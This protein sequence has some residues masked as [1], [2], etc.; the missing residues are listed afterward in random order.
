M[1]RNAIKN[2]WT[3]EEVDFSDRRRRPAQ[4]DD[5]GRAAS[6]QPSG[7]VLRDRR[8]DRVEQPGAQSLQAHQRA[9]GAACIC[10]GSC[11]RKRCTCSSISRCSTP[12]FP[13]TT[14]ARQAFA[15]VENIPSIQEQGGVL[16]QVDR[17]DRRARRA[18]AAPSDRRTFLLNLIC[19]A[20]CIEGLFFFAAF[21]YVYFLRSQGPAPRPRGGHQLG[22]PRRERAHDLRLR[23]GQHG[24][25]AK[26]RELF[27]A[28]LA[29]ADRR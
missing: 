16:L 11:T 18:R 13:T 21:A 4:Q 6:D 17:L 10:R 29:S 12:I 8:F 20:A 2:T 26:S 1:Y 23:G 27:D 19:F 9:R 5:A 25:H 28:E 14:S 15:A 22:V 7:R 3:V 24:A